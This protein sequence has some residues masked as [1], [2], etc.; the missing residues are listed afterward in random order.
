MF[1]AMQRDIN[2]MLS[3]YS[4][5]LRENYKEL[6]KQ[7][8]PRPVAYKIEKEGFNEDEFTVH[9][10]SSYSNFPY[11]SEDVFKYKIITKDSKLMIDEI[12]KDKSTEYFAK[13]N[14]LYKK[15]MKSLR[16]KLLSPLRI[17]PILHL[18]KTC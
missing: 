6:P 18:L 14:I 7:E 17:Y 4:P 1:H 2:A 5:K 16:L 12:K 11:F 13:G 15:K 10:F 9:I 3:Y 8:N